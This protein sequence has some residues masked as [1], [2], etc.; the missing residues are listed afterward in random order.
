MEAGHLRLEAGH[1]PQMEA[2]HLPQMVAGQMEAG[3]VLRRGPQMVA[4]QM[5]A[6][7]VLRRGPQMEVA[8]QMRRVHQNPL[9]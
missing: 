6:G 3:L 8:G 9:P 5:E 1:L 4:G 2:G 7:L